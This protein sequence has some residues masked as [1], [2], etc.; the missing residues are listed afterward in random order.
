[1][2]T[3]NVLNPQAQTNNNGTNQQSFKDFFQGGTV[4]PPLEKGEYEVY[5]KNI[6]FHD[7]TPEAKAKNSNAEGYVRFDLETSSGRPITITR[8]RQGFQIA[9]SQLMQQL[10]IQDSISVPE[11]VNLLLQKEEAISI[12]IDY[13][14][15][16]DGRTFR[17]ENFVPPAQPAQPTQPTENNTPTTEDF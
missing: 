1:M 6:T 5:F 3:N 7:P 13:V 14:T 8:F 9:A 4:H 17:N 16:E 11:L 2:T 15:L 12:W 10:N